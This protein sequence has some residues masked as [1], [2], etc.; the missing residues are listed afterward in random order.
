MRLSGKGGVIWCSE[1]GWFQ[2]ASR[3]G[4]ALVVKASVA[5]STLVLGT[6]G[7]EVNPTQP[8]TLHIHVTAGKGRWISCSLGLMLDIPNERRAWSL[9]RF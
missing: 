9:S 6:S 4:D 2:V 8:L 3:A 5:T 1:L 7:C